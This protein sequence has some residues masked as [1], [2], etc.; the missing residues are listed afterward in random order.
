AGRQLLL[1]PLSAAQVN[2][3][4]QRHQLEHRVPLG[5]SVSNGFAALTGYTLGLT[6]ALAGVFIYDVITANVTE[7]TNDGYEQEVCFNT[8]TRGNS[9]LSVC[10]AY[11]KQ[12]LVG[13][14]F[15]S[16]Q[17]YYASCAIKVVAMLP[18][19][20]TR[21]LVLRPLTASELRAALDEVNNDDTPN[22][23]SVSSALAGIKGFALGI[24]NGI[25][26]ALLYDVATSPA[27]IEY[28]TNLYSSLNS[29]LNNYI[30]S[31]SSS[32]SDSGTQQEVCF[33]S[34]SLNGDQLGLLRQAGEE[35][36]QQEDE[37]EEEQEAEVDPDQENYDF[38][39]GRSRRG[40][41][42]TCIV[43][44]RGRALIRHRRAL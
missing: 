6:K 29:T 37:F 26:G 8:R 1:R 36:Q 24:S 5:R 41:S 12:F 9:A 21:R 40:R 18:H 2:R 20:F 17:V 27:G 34:R 16:R 13:F 38:G 44:N 30:G 35:Q 15:S 22:G 7:E 23:R 42:I 31:G 25:G 4:L 32:S 33:D 3:I 14:R 19:G 43:I 39:H 10:F 11:A 28:L